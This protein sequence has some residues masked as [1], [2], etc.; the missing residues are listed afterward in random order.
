MGKTKEQLE[1][2]K[3]IAMSF[4]VKPLDIDGL[5]VDDLKK[6]A[7]Q[8]WDMIVQLESDKYDLEER[9]KRQDYDV[10]FKRDSIE[11]STH[12][13]IFPI[14]LVERIGRTSTSNQS[15]QGLEKG[16]GSRVRVFYSL[17][18]IIVPYINKSLCSYSALSG[19]FPPKI[20][21]AS[22]Y[23]RQ[24]DRRTFNDKKSLFEGVCFLFHIG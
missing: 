22:K 16:S 24:V 7:S 14:V 4:R 23:E 19:K 15:K 12:L 13:L 9:K 18:G 20:L 3:R 8:L 10:S 11:Y 2:D 5:S 1:E 21:T 6:K 17:V